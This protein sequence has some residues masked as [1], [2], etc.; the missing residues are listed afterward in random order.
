MLDIRGW[1][2]IAE[3]E[4]NKLNGKLSW[5]LYTEQVDVVG[6]T[7]QSGIDTVHGLLLHICM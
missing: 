1:R 5:F 7:A 3:S 6:D 4:R 2:I